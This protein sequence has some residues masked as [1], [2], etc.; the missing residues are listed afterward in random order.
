MGVFL[1]RNSAFI[2]GLFAELA[3]RAVRL[4]VPTKVRRC[5]LGRRPAPGSHGGA[6]G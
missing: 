3:R 6:Q 1:V 4:P 2:R 5:W